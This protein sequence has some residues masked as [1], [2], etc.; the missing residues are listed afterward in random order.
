MDK[1]EEDPANLGRWPLRAQNHPKG[2]GVSGD[3]DICPKAPMGP[4]PHVTPPCSSDSATL[5]DC[6]GAQ[7]LLERL[8]VE[9]DGLL[10]HQ[11]KAELGPHIRE[12]L[13]FNSEVLQHLK[14]RR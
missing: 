8:E 4:S 1:G 7:V 2:A 6:V 14:K 13:N 9:E 5:S 11:D 3:R 10:R 12:T